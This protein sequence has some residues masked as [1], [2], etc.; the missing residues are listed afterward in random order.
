MPILQRLLAYRLGVLSGAIQTG[1]YDLESARHY[2]HTFTE[3]QI[4]AAFNEATE[5]AE[6]L[7]VAAATAGYLL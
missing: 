5:V 4:D 6:R 3:D 7:R 2:W 1:I